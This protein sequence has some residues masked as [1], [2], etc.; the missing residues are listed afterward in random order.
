MRIIN[1]ILFLS[2]FLLMT[3]L[4]AQSVTSPYSFYGLGEINDNALAHNVAMGGAGSAVNEFL[5]SKQ[6]NVRILTLVLP[7]TFIEH[8]SREESSRSSG[9]VTQAVAH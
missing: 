8:G 9:P 4:K 1:G 6:A 7:D 3:E 5:L 2:A